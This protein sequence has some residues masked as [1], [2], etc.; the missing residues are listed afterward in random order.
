MACGPLV[1]ESGPFLLSTMKRQITGQ[2]R[3]VWLGGAVSHPPEV[4]QRGA[5]ERAQDSGCLGH[6]DHQRLAQS[7]SEDSP[8]LL[9]CCE[10]EMWWGRHVTCSFGDPGDTVETPTLDP[11]RREQTPAWRPAGHSLPLASGAV[12][13]TKLPFRSV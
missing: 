10:D 13:N 5:A 1:A 12:L 3:G 11:H 9:G 8:T 7:D 4:E 2:S 6:A